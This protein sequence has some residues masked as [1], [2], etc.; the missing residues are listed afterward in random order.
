MTRYRCKLS[1][2][3][4]DPVTKVKHERTEVLITHGMSIPTTIRI[5]KSDYGVTSPEK[6]NTTN[7]HFGDIPV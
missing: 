3:K 1:S 6:L 2:V 4:P 5:G 7:M